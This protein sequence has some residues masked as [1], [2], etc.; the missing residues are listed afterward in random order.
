[1]CEVELAS[2]KPDVAEGAEDY[3]E[4]SVAFLVTGELA[5]LTMTMVTENL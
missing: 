1:M 4:H 3:A 2:P 5:T